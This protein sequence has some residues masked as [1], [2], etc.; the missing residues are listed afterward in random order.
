[1]NWEEK[2]K[3]RN[4]NWENIVDYIF[5]DDECKDV[6]KFG[7]IS[8]G[9][10]YLTEQTGRRHKITPE[11]KLEDVKGLVRNINSKIKIYPPVYF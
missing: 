9:W 4:S 2:K 10:I 3:V 7:Y 5:K 8:E 6:H 1:M 11:S